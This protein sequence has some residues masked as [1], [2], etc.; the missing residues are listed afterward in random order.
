M[1]TGYLSEIFVSFQGEGAHVGCRHLFVRMAGC[2]LRCRYCD[3]PDSLER[4]DTYTVISGNRLPSLE[5]NPVSAEDLARLITGMIAREAPIDAIALTGGEP[6]AQSD[7]LVALLEA[8]RFP[9]PVLL[10][11]NGVLPRRL[12]E[13]LPLVN[14]IS[15]D[16]KLPSNTG[17]DAFWEEH[18]EFLELART[19]DLYVKILVDQKTADEDIERAAA[20][21]ASIEPSVPVF[22]QSIVDPAERPLID[23]D[24]LTQ[25]YLTARRR[26]SSIRV[27]PQTHKLLGI[28]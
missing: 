20:L 28:R 11:T 21:L 9:L 4:T 13:V 16:I 1:R 5:R 7:F 6:L 27:L 22:M 10:E 12:R 19:K 15:M 18:V 8:G 25:L 17:E 24:R 3:T 26:L 23:V 14:I 2:N